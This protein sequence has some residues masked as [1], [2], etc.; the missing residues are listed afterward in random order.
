MCN[1]LHY[2]LYTTAMAVEYC[3]LG[4]LLLYSRYFHRYSTPIH[5]EALAHGET[6]PYLLVFVS[7]YLL[8]NIN[9]DDIGYGVAIPC[10]ER[11]WPLP[12]T[13]TRGRPRSLNPRPLYARLRRCVYQPIRQLTR[14]TVRRMELRGGGKDMA[15]PITYWHP[16]WT[17]TGKLNVFSGPS[18]M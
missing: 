1:R 4:C 5:E 11:L 13:P 15:F 16:S 17:E 7:K 6:R 18:F 9:D 14:L 3:H 2:G 10:I 12:Y 8:H